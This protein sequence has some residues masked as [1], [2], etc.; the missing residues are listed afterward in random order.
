MG[1]QALM[2]AANRAVKSNSPGSAG[3]S[4]PSA[5]SVPVK[6]VFRAANAVRARRKITCATP[7]SCTPRLSP[8]TAAVEVAAATTAALPPSA[9]RA[10][11]RHQGRVSGRVPSRLLP[12]AFGSW[13][14]HK[15]EQNLICTSVYYDH[16]CAIAQDGFL[17]RLKSSGICH[18]GPSQTNC[19]EPS[20]VNRTESSRA[21]RNDSSPINRKVLS[22]PSSVSSSS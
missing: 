20:R 17:F 13:V 19:N 6:L 12:I 7:R 21:T 5:A 9:M 18:N 8:A 16:R 22:I 3:T 15:K 1:Y 14:D 2:A 10:T 11:T 4:M